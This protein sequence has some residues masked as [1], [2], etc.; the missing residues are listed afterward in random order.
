MKTKTLT[1]MCNKHSSQVGWHGPLQSIM[2]KN[3]N[4]Y[5]T[6]N[7]SISCTKIELHVLNSGFKHKR[8]QKITTILFI[9]QIK[10]TLLLK[11]Q[12]AAFTFFS[13]LMSVFHKQV[14]IMHTKIQLM[15]IL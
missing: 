2:K 6:Q 14:T 15:R 10:S 8:E 1:Q 9:S 12:C 13:C 7:Q 5:Q 3:Q 4:N 11:A